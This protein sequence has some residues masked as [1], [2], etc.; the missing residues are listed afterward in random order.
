[1]ENI[2]EGAADPS[3]LRRRSLALVEV[4]LCSGIPTQVLIGSLLVGIGLRPETT[5][6]RLTLPFVF[7]LSMADTVVVIALMVLLTRA[8]N[9]RL[10]TLWLGG[11]PVL[12]EVWLG[13]SLVPLVFV[14]VIAVMAGIHAFAPWLQN[15]PVNP[16]EQLATGGTASAVA[17][18]L[19]AIVAGG[20]REELQRAFLLHRFQDL[21]GM[22]VG[23]VVLS[24]GFGALHAVQGRDAMITTGVLGAFWAIVYLRRRSVVAPVV[25]HAGFNL[26]GVLRI[27][28]GE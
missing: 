27:A 6:D 10:S 22:W 17:F 28:V 20:L 24:V 23:V 14:L 8:R 21:G 16:L 25:S 11:R 18:G 4:L 2:S 7:W 26:L 9:E 1:M 13:L 5:P 19:V 3:T 12:Q 15:V